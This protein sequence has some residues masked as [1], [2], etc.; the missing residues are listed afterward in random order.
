MRELREQKF[1]DSTD[2]SKN[3]AAANSTRMSGIG[4]G[5][6]K[7]RAPGALSSAQRANTPKQNQIPVV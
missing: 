7:S 2:A 1:N 3:Q 4:S 6:L 5:V